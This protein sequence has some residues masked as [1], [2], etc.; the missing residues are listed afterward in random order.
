MTAIG[1][2]PADV[3]VWAGGFAASPL[4]KDAGICVNARNQIVADPFLRSV[5]QP[6]I[7]SAGDMAAPL[8]EPGAPM[9]MSLFTALVSGAQT[10]D[11]IVAAI[12]G[13]EP[14]PFSFAW[15]GQAIA[16]GPNDAAGFATYPADTPVGPVYRGRTAVA[17][18][19]FFVW[20]LK[21]A[22]ELE[23]RFPGFFFWNGRGR[24]ARQQNRRRSEAAC[25]ARRP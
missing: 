1:A 24:Y 23:R 22:L 17:L 8:E 19:R 16:L 7:F 11:N 6:E 14:Q 13:K 3:V 15:Y 5:T 9:R 20:Y 4:A 12:K 2:L 25:Q 18:R 10:A 21:A